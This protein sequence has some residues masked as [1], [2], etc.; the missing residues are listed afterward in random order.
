M[1]SERGECMNYFIVQAYECSGDANLDSRL[2]S[3]ID[4]FDGYLSPQEVAK[5]YIVTENFES[6]AQDGGVAF[7]DR[8]GNKMQSLEGMARWTPIIDDQK[9]SK[10]ESVHITW[11]MIIHLLRSINGFVQLYKS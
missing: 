5:K 4:N 7:T 6:F 10:G 9:V 3:T 2:K 8:Y 11:N 1:P